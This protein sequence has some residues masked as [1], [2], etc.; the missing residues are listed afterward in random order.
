MPTVKLRI[1][2]KV[3]GVGFRYHAAHQAAKYDVKGYAKNMI[4]KSI[5]IVGQSSSKSK[6]EQ[7]IRECRRG[8]LLSKIEKVE[9]EELSDSEVYDDFELY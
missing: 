2:G 7:F 3:Q 4:D 8:P 9:Q 5:E 6:L 1:Y